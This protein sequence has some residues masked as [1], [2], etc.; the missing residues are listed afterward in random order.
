MDTIHMGKVDNRD[1][2]LADLLKPESFF[3]IV[4]N[5]KDGTPVGYIGVKDTRADIWEIAE[6][7]QWTL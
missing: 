4:E 3:C 1:L 7:S 5:A 2:L 6:N